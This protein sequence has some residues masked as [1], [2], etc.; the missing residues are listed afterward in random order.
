MELCRKELPE[1]EAKRSLE[2]ACYFT[3]C[4]LQS[5]HMQLCLRAAMIAA[6]KLKNF[7]TTISMGRRLLELGPSP[8]SAQLVKQECL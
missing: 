4:Q 3:H 2:M 6:Y 7:A 1:A 8:Q 5:A